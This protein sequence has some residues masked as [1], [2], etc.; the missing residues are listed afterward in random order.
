QK[1]DKPFIEIA[2]KAILAHT[3]AALEESKVIDSIV[4]VIPHDKVKICKKL[5]KKH[6]L[7]KVSS[8]TPGGEE[9]F[10]SVKCGL[11][12]ARDADL[13]MIHDGARPF[14]EGALIKK[15]FTA[16]KK[17]GAA[18]CA[19]PLK[20]TLKMVSKNLFITKTLKRASLWEAQT[21]QAFRRNLIE[22]AYAQAKEKSPTDDSSL[23]ERLGHKV[24]IVMGS[25]RNIKIT[26]PEDLALARVLLKRKI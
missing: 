19:T 11:R 5:V 3:L 21:P 7:K 22:E 8:I 6:R 15:V 12:K 23:V 4:V 25:H 2:R 17:Y 26:T 14:I 20:Q 24:K 18:I 16:A 9:R 13:V 10:D 1:K